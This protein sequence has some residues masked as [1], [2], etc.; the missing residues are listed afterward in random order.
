[1]LK[2]L[3]ETLLFI[4][5]QQKWRFMKW[6]QFTRMDCWIF[7]TG[8]I[9]WWKHC[10]FSI[11]V[12]YNDWMRTY[13]I[14]LHVITTLYKY[15]NVVQVFSTSKDV[16][17][18]LKNVPRPRKKSLRRTAPRGI[19]YIKYILKKRHIQTNPGIGLTVGTASRGY[20]F[21]VVRV[22]IYCTQRKWY[23]QPFFGFGSHQRTAD[24]HDFSCDIYIDKLACNYCCFLQCSHTLQ[25]TEKCRFTAYQQGR[26]GKGSQ[27]VL[28]SLKCV[29]GDSL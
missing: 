24:R 19:S 28:T 6:L 4:T 7:L 2:V 25:H 20:T 27:G 5:W 3:H 15:G 22:L 18:V 8:Y 11:I 10:F 26:A 14:I 13:I 21:A 16:Y 9:F 17:I 29:W 23:V 12:N 1:M